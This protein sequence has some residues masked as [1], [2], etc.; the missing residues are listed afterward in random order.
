MFASRLTTLKHQNIERFVLKCAVW[1]G[2]QRRAD[3]VVAELRFDC[4][5]SSWPPSNEAPLTITT[6]FSL[7]YRHEH[8]K[9]RTAIPETRW[10]FHTTLQSALSQFKAQ[11]GFTTC[12]EKCFGWY[13]CK[14]MKKERWGGF[15]GPVWDW[16][17]PVQPQR[18]R[19]P[20]KWVGVKK[21]NKW[22]C[23]ATWLRWERVEMIV[24]LPSNHL[25]L[26][27]ANWK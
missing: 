19:H 22:S 25:L 20:G 3:K 7:G 11:F 24:S 16:C 21:K 1:D 14:E 26:L 12:K 2:W 8:W 17:S 15:E 13:K 18:E 10:H 23:N 4:H 6:L 27:S 5:G 9:C